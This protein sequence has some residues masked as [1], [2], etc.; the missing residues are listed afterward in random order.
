MGE[1]R[2]IG[3]IGNFYGGLNVKAEGGKFF[4]SIENYDGNHW[5][6]ISEHLY[7]ALITHDDEVNKNG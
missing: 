6:E 2:E 3:T 5:E 7:R 4:W 1:E